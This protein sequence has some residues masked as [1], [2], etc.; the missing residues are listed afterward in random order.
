[1]SDSC[2]H[3]IRISN[4]LLTERLHGL[5]PESAEIYKAT[6]EKGYIELFYFDYEDTYQRGEACD[7]IIRHAGGDNE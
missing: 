1:M 2:E 6:R 4:T 3:F 5:V 7:P